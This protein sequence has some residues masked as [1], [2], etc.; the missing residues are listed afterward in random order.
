MNLS[1]TLLPSKYLCTYL[2]QKV[3]ELKHAFVCFLEG[4]EGGE[5]Y[6]VLG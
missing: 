6:K 4:E 3:I 2:V 5:R 1:L